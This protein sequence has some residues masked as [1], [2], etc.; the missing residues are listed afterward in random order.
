MK[1]THYHTEQKGFIGLLIVFAIA[2]G[3]T[4]VIR[5]DQGV[6]YSDKIYKTVH[7]YTVGRG[8]DA[9][10]QAKDAAS[11]VENRHKKLESM[12]DEY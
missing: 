2:L 9:I 4:Y 8:E 12:I 6:R 5:D 11:Q 10:R 1:N 3:A 7:H